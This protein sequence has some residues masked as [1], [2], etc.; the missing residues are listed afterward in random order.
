MI[1]KISHNDL[2]MVGVALLEDEVIASQCYASRRVTK[3]KWLVQFPGNDVKDLS[4]TD[5]ERV[6]YNM[7]CIPNFCDTRTVSRNERN[8]LTCTCNLFEAIRIP[9]RH[10]IHVMDHDI[11]S[12]DVGVLWRN[13][14]YQHYGNP[15]QSRVSNS[16]DK[17]AKR[18]AP[19]YCET[20]T[21]SILPVLKYG[22][23]IAKAEKQ[24]I[25]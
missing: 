3:A 18:T 24:E 17:C 7:K 16:F 20:I 5:Q 12:L 4:T 19:V 15:G 9:C 21:P 14:Y 11:E 6:F 1:K 22:K 25:N 10:I 8:E 13:D 23:G 2:T